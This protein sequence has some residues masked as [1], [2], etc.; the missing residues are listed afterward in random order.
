MK[1]DH[2]NNAARIIQGLLAGPASIG[3]IRQSHTLAGAAPQVEINF[4][5]L[6][7]HAMSVVFELDRRVNERIREDQ[8]KAQLE[9]SS[10]FTGSTTDACQHGTPWNE[11]CE[12]CHG[13]LEAIGRGQL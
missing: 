13:D 11:D 4:D 10:V 9:A 3:Y 1:Q 12:G 6:M 8:K 7:D 2:T 5:L